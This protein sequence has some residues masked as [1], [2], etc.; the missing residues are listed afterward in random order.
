MNFLLIYEGGIDLLLDKSYWIP[1]F[2]KFPDD[3]D[4]IEF[5]RKIETGKGDVARAVGKRF[6]IQEGRESVSGEIGERSA[7]LHG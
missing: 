4:S 2:L 6:C 7:D 5:T 1:N 3:V